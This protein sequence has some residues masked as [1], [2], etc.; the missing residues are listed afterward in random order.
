MIPNDNKHK[1]H[2]F[3]KDGW[4]YYYARFKFGNNEFIGKINEGISDGVPS[5]YN[6]TDIYTP[7]EYKKMTENGTLNKNES[8]L[9]QSFLDN[10][11]SQSNKNVKS[12]TLSTKYSI[13]ETQNNTSNIENNSNIEYNNSTSKGR[14]D[15]TNALSKQEW[16]KFYQKTDNHGLESK[17]P[18]S[19]NITFVDDKVVL[20]EHDG[21]KPNIYDVY[22]AVENTNQIAEKY[23][24]TTE[25]IIQDIYEIAEEENVDERKIK[26][27]LEKYFK[28]G[29]L[30]RYSSDNN[31]F[32][33]E[34]QHARADVRQDNRNNREGVGRRENLSRI[35][36]TNREL[37]N[38][39]FSL[40]KNAKRYDDLTETSYIEY[41]VKDNNNNTIIVPIESE[42]TTANNINIDINRVKSIYG[43]DKPNP[44]LNKYIKDNINTNKFTKIFEQ[45]KETPMSKSQ[46]VL[47]YANNIPQSNE[48]VKSDTLPTNSN[49][50]KNCKIF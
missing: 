32:V 3:A 1:Y 35:N 12:D 37:D 4:N 50:K 15:F 21:E 6:V 16:Y 44:D 41:F 22:Q 43:Y 46:G 23:G 45:K 49:M 14:Q 33:S 5:F 42:T 20:S 34:N 39:S 31:A 30:R 11:I 40:D 27:S 24:L 9:I 29:L 19:K 48:K 38:S 28:E 10:N 36:Q 25:D 8:A 17:Q 18:G 13:E 2:N 47:P 7:K 26:N